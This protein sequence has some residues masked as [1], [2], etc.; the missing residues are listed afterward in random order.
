MAGGGNVVIYF[1]IGVAASVLFLLSLITLIVKSKKGSSQRYFLSVTLVA[2]ISV[3]LYLLFFQIPV[4]ID[5]AT[6]KVLNDQQKYLPQIS[7][8]AE[9]F[10]FFISFYQKK[11]TP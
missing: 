8:E 11:S 6:N 2:I 4:V 3:L 7:K 9:G 10:S 1:G 5:K